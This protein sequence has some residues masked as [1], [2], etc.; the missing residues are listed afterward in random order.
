MPAPR[1]HRGAAGGSSPS[2]DGS[3]A[4]G[5]AGPQRGGRYG[6]SLRLGVPVSCP[7][8]STPSQ[9]HLPGCGRAAGPEDARVHWHPP[10]PA[11]Y[12]ACVHVQSCASLCVRIVMS[13][14][15]RAC[16]YNIRSCTS[17][18]YVSR[19]VRRDDAQGPPPHGAR[20]PHRVH[21]GPQRWNQRQPLMAV[22]FFAGHVF[23]AAT[24]QKWKNKCTNGKFG[25]S[26]KSPAKG[27]ELPVNWT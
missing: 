24:S 22:V 26:P 2:W 3:K 18:R 21:A 7:P 25:K 19:P 5:S 15:M 8:L 1:H 20:R 27:R 14:V 12:V 4:H 9:V 13:V 6:S 17:A 23:R 10:R 11:R 16:T